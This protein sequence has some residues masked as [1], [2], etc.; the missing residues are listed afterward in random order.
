[1]KSLLRHLASSPR[2]RAAR[3]AA[4]AAGLLLVLALAL[5]PAA[6][7]RPT[8]HR[9][10][11]KSARAHHASHAARCTRRH[12]KDVKHQAKHSTHKTPVKAVSHKTAW[13]V[14]LHCENGSL[15][16]KEG[17]GEFSC[18]DESSP[19]CPDGSEPQLSSDGSALTCPAV[20]TSPPAGE[21][22]E[23]SA[24][25]NTCEGSG[26]EEVALCSLLEEEQ[27]S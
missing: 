20:A 14:P 8:A 1:M 6:L 19:S 13:R 11:C 21:G 3:P 2:A 12:K 25:E 5:A 15:P 4:A 7:G 24:L 18:E 10:A 22:E 26:E 27:E 9:S 17:P 16:V 23:E